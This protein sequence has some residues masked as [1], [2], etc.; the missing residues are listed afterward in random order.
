MIN[1]YLRRAVLTIEPHF[2]SFALGFAYGPQFRSGP[3]PHV[4]GLT[5]LSWSVLKISLTSL[6]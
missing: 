4:N 1:N 3:K 6:A 5:Q 2:V